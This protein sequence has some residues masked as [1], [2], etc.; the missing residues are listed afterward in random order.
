MTEHNLT[1]G[2]HE[3]MRAPYAQPPARRALRELAAAVFRHKR[4]CLLAFGAI[5]LGAIVAA[6]INGPQYQARMKILVQR[7][8]VDPVVSAQQDAPVQ[9]SGA[10]VTPEQINAEVELLR[11]NDVLRETVIATGMHRQ[12]GSIRCALFRCSREEKIARA[13]R[14]LSGRLSIEPLKNNNIITVTL[15]GSKAERTAKLLKALQANYLQ[16]HL[17]VHRLPGQFD[18]FSQ[19]AEHYRQEL[20]NTQQQLADLSEQ[21]RSPAPLIERDIRIRKLHDF[22]ATLEETRAAVKQTRDKIRT[23]Q[24]QLVSVPKRLTTSM[25]AADNGELLQSLKSKLLALEL[26]RTE[27]LSKFKPTY[28][29]VQQLETK[30]AQTKSAI[31]IAEKNPLRDETTD[32]DPTYEWLRSELVKARAELNAL[33]GKAAATKA[34]IDQYEQ[35]SQELNLKGIAQEQLTRAAKTNEQS[36]LFYVR[37][38]EEARITDAL[39]QRR[40]VN[41][42]VA[43]DVAVPVLP[44][45]PTWMYIAVGLI[46]AVVGSASLVFAAEHFDNSFRTPQEI[47]GTLGIPV[48]AAV[49]AQAPESRIVPDERSGRSSASEGSQ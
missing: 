33:Q 17:Q 1:P 36:Y 23:L 48:L 35:D 11:S 27:M 3:P 34:T 30:I 13:V 32:V 45:R 20:Q 18:F 37:K 26:E 47:E 49:P 19:Q 24:A 25:R 6:I 12:A 16:K 21:Q 9:A 5:L 40:I 31:A 29:P 44:S 39:D 8:R 42:A 15:N 43:E 14:G 22:E 10:P 7:E 41:V 46:A 2:S 28:R 4:L 38:R